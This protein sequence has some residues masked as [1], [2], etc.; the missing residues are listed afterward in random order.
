M[1]ALLMNLGQNLLAISSLP[2]PLEDETEPLD[3][4]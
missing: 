2:G 1:M 4:S 3:L